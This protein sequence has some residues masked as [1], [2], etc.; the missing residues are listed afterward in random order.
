M[1]CR[2]ETVCTSAN[3]HTRAAVSRAACRSPGH[4]TQTQS[5]PARHWKPP[6]GH[7]TMPWP[8]RG[9]RHGS[10]W[11]FPSCSRH[12]SSRPHRRYLRPYAFQIQT[13]GAAQKQEHWEEGL[14][15]TSSHTQALLMQLRYL[16]GVETWPAGILPGPTLKRI[17]VPVSSQAI[18][19][20]TLAGLADWAVSYVSCLH[21][22]AAVLVS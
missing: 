4:Q 12:A 19:H 14:A 18:I 11:R 6:R 21:R 5:K 13:A 7:G 20:G 8:E 10:R 3:L 15:K 16:A 9:K 2:K 17:I 22:L 1:C